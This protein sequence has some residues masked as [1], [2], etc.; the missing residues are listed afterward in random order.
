M[1]LELTVL[2]CHSATPRKNA[3]PT[4]QYLSIDNQ[5]GFLIDCGEGTQTRLREN[6]I[7]FSK[8]KQVFIS[9]LHGDHVFGLVGLIS[10]MSMLSREAPLTIHAPKGIREIVQIHIK[11]CGIFLGYSLDF[12][13][14]SSKKSQLIYEDKKITVRTLP[15]HHRVYTNGFLFTEKKGLRKLNMTAIN[16]NPMIAREDYN[17]L[18]N[19]TDFVCDK[20]GFVIPNEKLT[21]PPAPPKSYTFCSDTC[22][23]PEIIPLIKGVDLL[24]HEATFLAEHTDNAKNTLHSTATQAAEI[25]KKA[26]VKSLLLGHYS[27]RYKNITKFKIEAERIFKSVHLATSGLQISL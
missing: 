23:F 17:A 13:E 14:L 7:S 16:Q 5:Y 4:A 1:A 9:H 26:N 8:I 19:G 3:F 10:T 11:Y 21:L 12:K 20:T 27:S 22:Y 6:G 18:K 24:Y 25:A 15:L 2:G